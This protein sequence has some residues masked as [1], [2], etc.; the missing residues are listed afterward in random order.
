MEWVAGIR[1]VGEFLHTHVAWMKEPYIFMNTG[2]VT[3]SGWFCCGRCLCIFVLW[4]FPEFYNAQMTRF[5]K[6]LK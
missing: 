4:K 1:A 3:A 5:L 2:T 6:K